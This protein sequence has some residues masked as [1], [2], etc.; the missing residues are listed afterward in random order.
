MTSNRTFYKI[1]THDFYPP[2]QGGKPIWDG[3]T[4]P[5]NYPRLPWIRTR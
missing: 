2:L 1:L 3:V 4:L 5:S